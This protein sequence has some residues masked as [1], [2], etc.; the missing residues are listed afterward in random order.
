[1]W[2]RPVRLNQSGSPSDQSFLR[3]S[4]FDS[5][6]DDVC[7][8]DSFLLCTWSVL[9]CAFQYRPLDLG[10]SWGWINPTL[11]VRLDSPGSIK[12]LGLGRFF[13]FSGFLL[14]FLLFDTLSCFS[15]L[16]LWSK[17]L[18]KFYKFLYMFL[19]IFVMFL[20]ILF[21]ENIDEKYYCIFLLYFFVF[22]GNS[23]KF[24]LNPFQIL[25]N[26]LW[27]TLDNFEGAWATVCAWF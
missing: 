20:C 13:G 16:C 19:L 23:W 15:H 4:P 27:Y 8:L 17:L 24:C 10:F 14:A 3:F 25:D 11:P 18:E 26:C 2:T 7:G 9:P 6:D 12:T 21:T 5:L 22:C 1:V